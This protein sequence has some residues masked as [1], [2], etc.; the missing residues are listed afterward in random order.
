M[1]SKICVITGCNSGIGK[2]AA[3]ELPKQGFEIIM[4]VRDSQKS[5]LAYEQIKKLS[6]GKVVLK[7]V[8][9]ASLKSIK[10]A[11]DDIKSQYKRVDVLI[12]NAGLIKRNLEKSA[13]NFEMTLAV[14]YFAPFVL[15]VELLPLLKGGNA[16]II[17]V[18]SE[19][20]KNGE[21]LLEDDFNLKKYNGNKAY[22]NTKL[23]LVY[24]TKELA[25]QVSSDNI[26]VNCVHP[27]VVGTDVFRDY[28]KWY[29]KLLN[30]FISKPNEGAE[31]L[32]YL[33]SSKYIENTTGTYFYKTEIKETA[34]NANNVVL[35]RS[36]WK[37]TESLTGI[38]YSF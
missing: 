36:I 6:S 5:R 11:T 35:S 28:P 4:L 3:I 14:N 38:N 13:D 33:A 1:A 8:D 24:F 22:A 20:Y 17:N 16:R 7:Y 15:T 18:T 10:K 34:S 19:L 31:P 23:L 9:L 29:A 37:K 21:V 26:T 12:N 30:M 27:G 2:A 32:V 25:K